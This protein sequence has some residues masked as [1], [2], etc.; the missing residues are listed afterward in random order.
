MRNS[1]QFVIS[2]KLT[3]TAKYYWCNALHLHMLSKQHSEVHNSPRQHLQSSIIQN[4][5]FPKSLR[6]ETVNA[7]G[8]RS[9]TLIRALSRGGS[10]SYMP[11]N[12][13]S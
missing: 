7:F 4:S 12:S 9:A 1:H 13:R 8:A 6:H 10:S 3:A 5:R 11:R 2:K